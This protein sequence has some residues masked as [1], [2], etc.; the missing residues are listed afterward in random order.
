M[1]V[2][3]EGK[4]KIIRSGP[5]ED[6]VYLETK[7]LLTGGDAA[8]REIITEIGI[9]KT[10]QAADV[11]ALLKRYVLP[12]AFIERTSPRELLCQR[13]EMLPL[14]LVVRRFAWGSFLLRHPEYR[15]SDNVP[16]RFDKPF[17]EFFHKWSVVASP[18]TQT[19]Y[20]MEEDDAREK[21]LHEGV[22]AKGV[23]T[24]PYLEIRDQQWTVYPAKETLSQSQPLMQIKPLC[25]PAEYH[26]IINSLMIPAFLA[27]EE[28]WKKIETIHGPVTLVDL[29]LEVGWRTLDRKLVIADVI[30]NDSWRIWPGGDPKKQLDKQC[31]RDG[32][33]LSSIAE[34]Y[35]LVTQL[36]NQFAK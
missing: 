21:F 4:T 35:S 9:D 29:K 34:K 24:D 30:D 32:H 20:Q 6:T 10:A 18:I 33:P 13:C 28:A 27:L 3:T 2:I 5:S 1:S 19:P 16:I 7:D 11:F 23:F 22:W 14:E 8:R 26:E 12:V 15:T 31:F 17:C 36:T 25:T